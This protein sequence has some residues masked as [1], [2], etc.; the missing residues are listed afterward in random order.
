MPK[1]HRRAEPW[2]DKVKK[3]CNRFCNRLT[4]CS[5]IIEK[6]VSGFGM[7]VVTI[8]HETAK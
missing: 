1:A 2:R 5:D 4:E 6:G 7:P 3:T 8:R